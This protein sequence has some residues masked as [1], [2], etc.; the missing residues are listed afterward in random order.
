M[1]DDGEELKK[2]ISAEEIV[3]KYK[4]SYQTTNYYTNLD[5]FEV[6]ETKGNKRF[7]DDEAIGRRL[8]ETKFLKMKGYSLKA[9]RNGI[10]KPR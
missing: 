1:P 5:L 4:I 7:Y 8:K 9:I 2:L 10:S 6:V 3:K